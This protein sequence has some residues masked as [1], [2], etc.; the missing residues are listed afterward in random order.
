MTWKRIG[1]VLPNTLLGARLELHWGAQLVSAVG[2]SL[3]APEPDFSHT[4][5][6]WDKEL[7]LLAG[8]PAGEKALRAGLVFEALE[9][10]LL[11][12]QRERASLRLAGHTLDEGRRW[13]AHQ[14][15]VASDEIALPTHDLPSHEIG[16]G[17]LFSEAHADERRELAAW[18]DNAT[19]VLE[20]LVAEDTAASAVR[21]WPHHFDLASL[22]ALDRGAVAE[23]ARSI[24]VGFSPGDGS[25]GQPYFY[26]TPWP[27]PEIGRLPSLEGGASWHIEGWT[28]AVL[29]ADALVSVPHSNRERVAM[30]ALAHAIEVSRRLLA[31]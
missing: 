28:G 31:G 22:I 4:N 18:F 6:V 12:S 2:T 21:C 16:E 19:R 1:S 30:R 11:H 15:G 26:V 24:G 14:L 5:A 25:Y 23:D 8:R 3:L 27:Y 7:G 9:L 17:G 13:L 10:V 20:A 29:T